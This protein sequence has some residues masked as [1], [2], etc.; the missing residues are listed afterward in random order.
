M[1][2]PNAQFR[3]RGALPPWMASSKQIQRTTRPIKA[4]N[5]AMGSMLL[6]ESANLDVGQSRRVTLVVVDE[7][8]R[9]PHGAS[10]MKSLATVGAAT[11]LAS[12]P[13]G[14]GTEFSKLCMMQLKE[15]ADRIKVLELG[16]E[17]S[18]THGR[19]RVWTID[20]DGSITG[21]K[22]SGYWE[23]PAFRLAR[24]M[25]PSPKDWRENW[26]RDHDT[27]GLLVLNSNA[28]AN[29]RRGVKRPRIGMI[30]DGRFE[31]TDRGRLYL[32][33]EP[34]RN[35]NYVIGADFAQGVEASNTVLAILDRTTRS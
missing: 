20:D 28:L 11:V 26:L 29:L 3:L 4:V 34:N 6:G 32:W 35:T 21:K 15:P 14:P 33:E 16:Y 9:F 7:A 17:S 23:T 22:G 12:T 10:L 30:V 27:S 5:P 13:N 18:P 19:G 25:L 31:E 24:K 1:P 2:A 8:A